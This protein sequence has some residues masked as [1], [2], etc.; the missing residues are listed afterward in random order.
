MLS[1]CR[2]ESLAQREL[3]ELF[4]IVIAGVQRLAEAHRDGAKAAEPGTTDAGG[5]AQLTAIGFETVGLGDAAVGVEDVAGVE[6]ECR[7]HRALILEEGQREDDF[8]AHLH[9]HV[10]AERIGIVDG[11]GGGAIITEGAIGDALVLPRAEIGGGIAGAEGVALEATDGAKTTA[12]V[13]L[14][15]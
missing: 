3:E 14:E 12:V 2:S 9:Q 6:E 13:V 7:L 1:S 15:E 8:R 5:I 10:A 11:H 4:V